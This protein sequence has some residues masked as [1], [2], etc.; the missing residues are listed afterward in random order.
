MLLFLFLIFGIWALFTNIKQNNECND[1]PNLFLECSTSIFDVISFTS[2]KTDLSLVIQQNEVCLATTIF[3]I[4]ILQKFRVIQQNTEKQCD[5]NL[6]SPSDYT[7]M[8]ENLTNSEGFEE[9]KLTETI[10]Q[11][12]SKLVSE[13]LKQKK[14]P[15]FWL[16]SENHLK[17]ILE[18]KFEIKKVIEAYDI[19][20]FIKLERKRMLINK[21][22]RQKMGEIKK[23][24]L[25]NKVSV[26][27]LETISKK[28]LETT[29]INENVELLKSE[30]E[31]EMRLVVK[32]KNQNI[33]KT[34][35]QLTAIESE[36]IALKTKIEALV[37]DKQCPFSFVTL[38]NQERNLFFFNFSN[39]NYF[40]C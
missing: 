3:L 32:N 5:D 7:L 29:N 14:K 31:K 18:T 10:Q 37:M 24:L 8:I 9:E 38:N 34:F 17:K 16:Q 15:V 19:G 36:S 2:K 33:L 13:I 11:N 4:F 30:F 22:K 23:K 20:D 27:N 35:S 28:F 21:N 39:E 40:R 26:E 25:K 1:N 6:I 12:W